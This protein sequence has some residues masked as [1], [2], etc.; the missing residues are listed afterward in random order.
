MHSMDL[1]LYGLTKVE[2]HSN[3]FLRVRKGVVEKAQ[4]DITENARF[5]EEMV[6]G[7]SYKDIPTFTSRIC[8]VC[9][10][11]Y[12]SASVKAI[13]KAFG[14]ETTEQT[15]LMQNLMLIGE[16]IRSHTLHLYFFSLPD[17]LGKDS[18]LDFEE[19]H[20]EEIHRAIRIKKVA[21]EIVK[22]FGGRAIH[23][24][25]ATIGGFKVIPYQKQLNE[26]YDHLKKARKDAVKCI[27]LFNSFKYECVRPSTYI[28][29]VNND[30]SLNTGMVCSNKG[31]CIPEEEYLSN[32]REYVVSFSTAKFAK[33][34]G[35]E[36]YVGALSRY[37][38]MHKRI[39]KETR[40]E[41]NRIGVKLKEQCPYAN[42]LAQAVEILH[43]I[44]YA[45]DKIKDLK[46]REES[47]PPITPRKSVG[48]GVVEAPRGTL[49]HSY[50]FDEK[51]TVKEC[52]LVV[53]TAQ[54]VAS[55]ER[56]IKLFL[57]SLLK[58]PKEEIS[59][60]MEKLIRAYDP[61]FSCSAHFLKVKWG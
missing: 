12:V 40:N 44:D 55:I 4:L 48:I 39:R 9:S 58:K 15:R 57:P 1:S 21:S 45:I 60:E 26:L 42:N 32:L 7:R 52:N 47:I 35:E 10:T 14:V 50:K 31:M 27:E 23:P 2:G 5:F 22:V 46:L 30:Y 36:F 28:S 3:L 16:I 8:G 38:L 41:L 56:D 33:L 49:Y 54:N 59:L 20:H 53:P 25:N 34:F 51:G 18:I 17:Y 13:E 29:L 6:V 19:K 37:N 43:F 11:S 24:V 61:C